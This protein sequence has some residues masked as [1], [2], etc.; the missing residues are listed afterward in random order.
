MTNLSSSAS[1]TDRLGTIKTLEIAIII[2]VDLH[3]NLFFLIS[4]HEDWKT[5]K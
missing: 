5:R 2:I 3:F 4:V 1:L